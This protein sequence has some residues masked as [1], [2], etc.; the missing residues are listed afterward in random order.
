MFCQLCG[1]EATD[2]GRFCVRCGAEMTRAAGAQPRGDSQAADVPAQAP[3]TTPLARVDPGATQTVAADAPALQG[4]ATHAAVTTTQ[5]AGAP[6]ARGGLTP[7]LGGIA[8]GALVAA[9]ALVFLL[10]GGGG[11]TSRRS[12]AV[13]NDSNADSRQALAASPKAAETATTAG[14]PDAAPR[15]E[16]KIV[17]DELLSSDD[18]LGLSTAELRR[19]R[20]AAFARHGRV[21]ES[22]ELQQYFN[23]RPWYSPRASFSDAQ[24]TANDRANIELLKTAEERPGGSQNQ[25]R[26]SKSQCGSIRDEK[27][28][29]E[30]FVGP[31]RNVSWYEANQWVGRLDACGGGWRMPTVGD[32]RSLYDPASTAG[33]GFYTGGRYFPA[34]INPIFSAIGGG[35]WV[36]S[37]E[38][39]GD[40]NARSFNLNQGKEVEYA[41]ANTDYST[42]VFA[43]RNSAN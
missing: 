11:D 39:V 34:H 10:R 14:A 5:W 33:T 25:T 19:L 13:R 17:G 9:A 32:I 21:F 43:V 16:S 6:P 41:A 15:A 23:S 3:P 29:L 12:E 24:L 38:R 26:F 22:P 40:Y 8:V 35:S 36:W 31:D 7:W 42:R 4:A 18:L 30:W 1:N 2:G 37:N 20:N 28:R 27:T